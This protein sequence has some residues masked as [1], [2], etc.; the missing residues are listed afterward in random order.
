MSFFLLILDFDFVLMGWEFWNKAMN[1]LR[2]SKGIEV[3]DDSKGI[4]GK[5]I[6]LGEGVWELWEELNEV[7]VGV[8]RRIRRGKKK[9]ERPLVEE[10]N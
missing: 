4:V 1:H 3:V 6:E 8:W 2:S 7:I 5:L 9:M 10:V